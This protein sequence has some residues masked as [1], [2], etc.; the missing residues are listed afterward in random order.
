MTNGIKRFARAAVYLWR[1]LLLGGDIEVNPGPM[2]KAQEEKLDMVFNAVQRLETSNTNMLESVNKVLQM[3][4][5]LK[6]DL[7]SLTK[8]VK[9]VE[10][11]LESLSSE[12]TISSQNDNLTKIQNQI[13][14][15][16]SKFASG[17]STQTRSSSNEH[18][19]SVMHDKIDDLENRS[20]R[21]NLLFYGIQI[22]VKQKTGTH[23][24]K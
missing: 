4:I 21:S 6:N 2:T 8:R 5:V 22:R 16:K 19:M 12:T 10:G 13:Q 24:S 11:K 9:E 3:H 17:T 14:D 20:R 7:D 18:D 23:P 1:I 15:L